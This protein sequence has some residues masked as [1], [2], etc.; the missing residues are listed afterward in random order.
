MA[1]QT[2]TEE[3]KVVGRELIDTLKKIVR[4]G[5]VRRVVVRSPEGRTLLDVP[6]AAGVAGALLLPVWATLA[7]VI[8]FA[9]DYTIVVERHG[10][11]PP[12]PPQP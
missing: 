2:I 7:S 6:L 1:D 8:A 4:E 11:G 10:G 12:A 5:G 9:A 3:F